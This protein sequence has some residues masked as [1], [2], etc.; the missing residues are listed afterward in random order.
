MLGEDFRLVPEFGLAQAQAD[1]WASAVAASANSLGY[2]INTAGIADPV[3][4][5]MYGVARVRP[6]VRAWERAGLLVDALLGPD[7]VS[8]L[9]PAQFPYHAGAAWVAM[10]FPPDQ[11][12]DSDRLCYT[13]HYAAPFDKNARQCGLML[14]E[15]TEVIPATTRDTGITFNFARP[16]NEPPQAILLVAPASGTGTWQWDDLVGALNETLDLAKLRAV[17]PG[18]VDQTAYSVLVPAT[19]TA[20]TVY[21]ISIATS[22]VVAEGVV[23]EGVVGEGVRH[24]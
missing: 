11:R 8:A 21:A 4:E 10:Q 19:I 24:A 14:D 20:A 1:E 22:L 7:Q 16:D 6:M 2:L 5:W 23:A 9:L 3:S 12:P 15:W 13:A 17:E 18:D